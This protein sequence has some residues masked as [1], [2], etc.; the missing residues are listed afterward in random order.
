M[1]Q[2]HNNR[3]NF[4]RFDNE[5]R[6]KMVRLLIKEVPL[7]KFLESPTKEQKPNL[8]VPT[9]DLTTNILKNKRIH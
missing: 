7:I 6:L 9:K 2:L 5:G 4:K 1:N 8:S 3:Y